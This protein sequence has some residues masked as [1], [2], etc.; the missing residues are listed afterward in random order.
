VVLVA[1]VLLVFRPSAVLAVLA[2]CVAAA[3]LAAVG[4]SA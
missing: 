1:F 3:V 4:L 2:G